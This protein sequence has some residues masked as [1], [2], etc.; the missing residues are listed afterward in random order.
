MFY[1]NK[2]DGDNMQRFKN[3]VFFKMWV[4][5]DTRDAAMPIVGVIVLV[6]VVAALVNLFQ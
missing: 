1:D 6:L 4:K 5:N 3:G 2:D